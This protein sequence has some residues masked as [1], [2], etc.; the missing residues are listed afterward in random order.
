MNQG[1]QLF[2]APNS[3]PVFTRITALN[4]AAY[5]GV[6]NESADRVYL[7]DRTGTELT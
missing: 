4:L 5:F 1:T 2:V 7:F 6:L 3:Y